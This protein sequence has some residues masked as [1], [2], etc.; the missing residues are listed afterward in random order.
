M[1]SLRQRILWASLMASATFASSG[2]FAQAPAAV[3][4]TPAAEAQVGTPPQVKRMERGDRAD[5]AK[6]MARMQEHRAKRLAALKDKLKITTAQEGAW[7]SFTA[8]TQPPAG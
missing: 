6:R 2:A 7:S 1:I 3:P 4:A 5:P 8:S